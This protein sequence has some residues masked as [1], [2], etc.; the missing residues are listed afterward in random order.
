MKWYLNSKEHGW[1]FTWW[2]FIQI[3]ASMIFEHF[4]Y[5][6]NDIILL[7]L[8]NFH[9]NIKYEK[10]NTVE[11]QW[12]HHFSFKR[13]YIKLLQEPED[14]SFCLKVPWFRNVYSTCSI[15]GDKK[16]DTCSVGFPGCKSCLCLLTLF[17]LRS[18]Q[19][20]GQSSWGTCQNSL[21]EKHVCGDQHSL[22]ACTEA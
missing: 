10:T 17:H 21:S 8:H 14:G 9:G 1:L 3:D 6:G 16:E 15:M 19:S 20:T 22:S 2:L 4:H 18:V 11:E 12:C 5:L 13:Y 7:K